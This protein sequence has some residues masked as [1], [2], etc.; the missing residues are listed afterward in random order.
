[1][2]DLPDP[3]SPD[4]PSIDLHPTV[5]GQAQVSALPSG[6]SVSV[7]SDGQCEEIEVRSPDGEIEIRL[8]LTDAGPVLTLR[9][10][11]LEIQSTDTI[12]L[13]CRQFMVRAEDGVLMQTSGDI[14]VYSDA[15]IRVK[16]AQQTFIDGD[17]VNLNCLDRNGYHD[18]PEKN[19]ALL[20]ADSGTS[21]L[22]KE[23]ADTSGTTLPP[24]SCCGDDTCAPPEE[25]T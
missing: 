14:G 15:E 22:P 24:N 1:M 7:T 8:A 12:A 2:P 25:T 6:R 16:S 13:N 20:Q 3:Q 23:P 19:P 17:Y 21:S 4:E 5:A 10:A 11:R 18:D 9:G